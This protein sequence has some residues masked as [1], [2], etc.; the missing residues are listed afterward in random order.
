M[1]A[2]ILIVLR[3]SLIIFTV[4]VAPIAMA[5]DETETRLMAAN[6][7]KTPLEN[8]LNQTIP[9]NWEGWQDSYPGVKCAR[10]QCDR[11]IQ[12]LSMKCTSGLVTE[13]KV[14]RICAACQTP[15]NP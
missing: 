4:L 2:K 1:T 12:V 6:E 13:V 3:F 10:W 14:K 15:P 5:M 11:Y 8:P 7:V 9:C